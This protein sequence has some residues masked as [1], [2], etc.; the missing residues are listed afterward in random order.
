M[1]SGEELDLPAMTGPVRRRRR[2]HRLQEPPTTG[3]PDL[4]ERLKALVDA[5]DIGRDADLMFG[6]VA[7]GLRLGLDGVGRGD[8][9]LVNA[10]LREFARAFRLFAPYKG[11][12][13][14]GIFGS[15]RAREADPEYELT[16][17]FAN[18]IV[19]RGWMVITGAGPGLMQAAQEGAGREHSFGLNI[20]LPFA[21]PPNRTIAADPKLLNFRYFFT[22]KVTFLKESDAVVLVPG[23]FGTLDEAFELLTLVQT[24]KSELRPVVMLDHPGGTYW[25]GWH[26]FVEKHL[27]ER[28]LIAMD[29]M[30]LLSLKT[31]VPE[32]A[33]EI[34]RFYRNYQS[35]RY[36][37][38]LLVLRLL[39]APTA[40]QLEALRREFA[41]LLKAGAT[42]EV[43]Q[44]L[45]AEVA[46]EDMLHLSRLAF[47]FSRRSYGRLR[48]FVD[49]LNEL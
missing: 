37:G 43:I 33:D 10:A 17:R 2:V 23:G 18:E 40:S 39:R 47:R 13:K 6:I 8:L 4:D 32:A 14:V 49:V 3:H 42:F 46:D 7:S 28:G 44:P 38:D 41:D 22:R 26:E 48:K 29:D 16:K 31:S 19:E 24:G 12:R 34:T 20:V 30:N 9:K 25:S 36:V 27:A 11:I 45:P 35:Q 1:N 15:S 5:A 21:N